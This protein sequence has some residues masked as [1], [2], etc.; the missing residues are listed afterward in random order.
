MLQ[1]ATMVIIALTHYLPNSL[2]LYYFSLSPPI[3]YLYP[4]SEISHIYVTAWGVQGA[5]PA[6]KNDDDDDDDWG[7][8]KPAAPS[9]MKPPPVVAPNPAIKP[10]VS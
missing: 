4:S 7:D 6:K 1:K 2:L 3:L 5:A 8:D 9:P 10:V